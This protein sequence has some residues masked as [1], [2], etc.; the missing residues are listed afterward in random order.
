MRSSRRVVAAAAFS[1]VLVAGTGTALALAAS[2]TTAGTCSG[3]GA[4]AACTVAETVDSPTSISVNVTSS[5]TTQPVVAVTWQA[6]CSLNG[7]TA[8]TSGSINGT[9]PE[10][11]GVTLGMASPAS[12]N[13]TATGTVSGTGTFLLAIDYTAA[14][15]ATPTAT[16]TATPSPSASAS[17]SPSASPSTSTA[18]GSQITGFTGVC[19][20]DKANRSSLGNKIEI[21]KCYTPESSAQAWLY[22]NGELVHNGMCANDAAWGGRGT[23][24]ILWTCNGAANE[25]WAHESDGEYVLAA[26]GYR[27]CLDD[28]A[29]S[30]TAGT[31]VIVYSCHDGPNQ[32]WSLP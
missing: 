1:G 27:L 12:C 4:S 22:T 21:W 8:T 16:A 29:D 28:P 6:V 24:I 25:I 19:L 10:T 17:P 23:R 30:T 14:A 18:F 7:D 11:G 2:T 3:A 20:D 26:N 9:V 32:A 15:S 5:D 31:P 13:V